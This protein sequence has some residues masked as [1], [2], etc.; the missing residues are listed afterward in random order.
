MKRLKVG[1]T[2]IE[3]LVVIAIISL[4][5]A[6]LFPVFASVR[7][8]GRQTA[9]LSNLEQ[10]G[11]AFSLYA[12]DN[13]DQF[14]Y[15]GDPV[16]INS[17]PNIWLTDSKGEFAVAAATLKPL[18]DVLDPYIKN[19][20]LWRCPSDSGF[21]Y[22]DTSGSGISA[23][24]SSYEQYGSSYYYRTT[25]AFKHKTLGTLTGYDKFA[26][27]ATH[28]PAEIDILNDG[29]G[30]WHGGSGRPD[31]KYNVLYGDFHSKN[32]TRA[33]LD[34]SRALKLDNPQP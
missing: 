9:C 24:P 11:L 34:A 31:W 32:V 23:H 2:L 6:L 17:S 26:P 16:D 30:T 21:D 5:A 22:L 33:M 25:L 1:F 12:H 14:A 19:K 29:S 13:D 7:A 3:L 8:K 28:G 15:G 4:L 20:D 27:Y 18:P 10:M